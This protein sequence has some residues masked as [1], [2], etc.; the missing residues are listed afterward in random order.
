M[1]RSRLL[2]SIKANEGY[3]QHPYLD[4]LGN[5]TVGWGHNLE[6]ESIHADAE[7]VGQ[8]L[9]HISQKWLHLRWLNDDADNATRLAVRW[10]GNEFHKM[11]DLRRE[12]VVEMFFQMGDGA[13]FPAMKAALERGD[14]DLAA[15]EMLDSKWATQTPERAT[16]L[17]HKF[18]QATV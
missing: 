5:W 4:H 10:Y 15:A 16:R 18:A 17:A 9:R 13:R 7:T 14:T 3:C 8:M 1:K 11:T 6:H 12:I 2:E